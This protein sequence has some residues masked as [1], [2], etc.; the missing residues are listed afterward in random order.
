[1]SNNESQ[2]IK[3][4]NT[5]CSY[6][7]KNNRNMDGKEHKCTSYKGEGA[8]DIIGDKTKYLFDEEHPLDIYFPIMKK[9]VVDV[10]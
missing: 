10:D 5:E 4:I 9:N 3:C 6:C 1:M 8:S 2:C 7:G